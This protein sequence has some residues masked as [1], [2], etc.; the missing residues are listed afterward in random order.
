MR[1]RANLLH[2]I[3]SKLVIE[4]LSEKGSLA[5]EKVF[6]GNTYNN[7]SKLSFVIGRSLNILSIT[8]NVPV[9]TTYFEFDRNGC[10]AFLQKRYFLF[11]SFS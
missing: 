11:V 1:F 10:F 4:M 6:F 5:K 9:A 8:W 2:V 7:A 3:K